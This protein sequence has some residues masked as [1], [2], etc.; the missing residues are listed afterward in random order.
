MDRRRRQRRSRGPGC[1]PHSP[2]GALYRLRLIDPRYPYRDDHAGQQHAFAAHVR[3]QWRGRYCACHPLTRPGLGSLA[4]HLSGDGVA[5]AAIRVSG[6]SIPGRTSRDTG[7][8]ERDAGHCV[9]R[10]VGIDPARN[11]S[12]SAVTGGVAVGRAT[13]MWAT[14]P[15]LG[16][17]SPAVCWRGPPNQR[18][19]HAKARHGLG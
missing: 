2:G 18:R 13:M 8:D 14:P 7:D 19:H 10:P 15:T 11:G 5:S 12:R 17:G 4:V 16:R 9:Q 6:L 3:S 1:N